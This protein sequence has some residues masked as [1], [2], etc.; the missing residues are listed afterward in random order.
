MTIRY[1]VLPYRTGSK[2]AKALAEGL[3]GKVLRLN[4]RSTFIDRD[5]DVIVNW[6]N[7]G[8]WLCD[9]KVFNG[10]G[11]DLASNKWKFFH[12]MQSLDITPKFWTNPEEISDEDFP[13][14][15]RTI[16][17]GHSGAGI[18]IADSREDLVD[19]PLYVKYVK[20]K[21]EYRVHL[22][23]NTGTGPDNDYGLHHLIS[24]Q[25]KAR[26]IDCPDPNWQVR[27]HANGFVYVRE[28]VEAPAEVLKAA[29]VSF[30][31]SGLDFGAV[32]VIWNE[33]TEKAYVLEIN[34]APG[35]EGTTVQ[36]YVNFFKESS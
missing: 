32:D 2:S 4:N 16:L 17:N 22:G 8:Q 29:R 9:C 33:K 5:D 30:D 20:K 7:T 23:R 31:A 6:G 11:I 3:G 24:L 28:G 21:E 12:S 13:V 1:R 36:D 14:V 10:H 18:V 35:L 19:A 34:T 27:N 15:C 26:R 25:R